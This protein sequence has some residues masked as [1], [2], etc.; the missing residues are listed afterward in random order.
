MIGRVLAVLEREGHV[1]PDEHDRYHANASYLSHQLQ[2]TRNT[3]E[4]V[5]RY[6]SRLLVTLGAD[7]ADPVLRQPWFQVRRR[8]P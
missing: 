5:E 8:H 4:L 3:L 7:P 6:T 2:L 1:S